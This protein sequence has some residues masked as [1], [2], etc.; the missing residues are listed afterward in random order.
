MSC[1]P[2]KAASDCARWFIPDDMAVQKLVHPTHSFSVIH[3]RQLARVNRVNSLERTRVSVCTSTVYLLSTIVP[4]HG[5]SSIIPR[6][7]KRVAV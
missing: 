5:L 4:T 2:H 3:P 1:I 7:D 6:R